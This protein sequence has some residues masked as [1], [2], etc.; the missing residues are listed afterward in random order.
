MKVY[1]KVT[2][3]MEMKMAR[4]RFLGGG[5]GCQ[6]WPSGC[7]GRPGAEGGRGPRKRS[8]FV[9]LGVSRAG[10]ETTLLSVSHAPQ[11]PDPSLGTGRW[12]K[13]QTGEGLHH[14]LRGGSNVRM[15]REN[16][17]HTAKLSLAIPDVP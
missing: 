4:G 8:S 6:C 12:E 10:K 5:E 2:S 17:V 9:S 7:W 11:L 3:G 13:G 16:P 14:T 15:E 1:T